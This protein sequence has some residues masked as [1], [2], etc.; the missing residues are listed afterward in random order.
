[1]DPEFADLLPLFVG[2]ARGRVERLSELAARLD[3]DGSAPPEARRE[4]HTL[5]GA[6][7]MLGLAPLAELCHAAEGALKAPK[8]GTG[9]L[10]T[11]VADGLAVMVDAVAQS[12]DPLPDPQLL[13]LLT[14]PDGQAPAVQTPTGAAAGQAASAAPAPSTATMDALADRATRLRILALGAGVFPVRLLEL[15][16]L[17]EAAARGGEPAQAL[18]VLATSLRH[19]GMELEAGQKRLLRLAD[20]HVEKVLTLQVQPLRA[21]FLTV[22]RY[23]REL[24]RSLGREAEIAT[25]GEDTRLDRRILRVIEEAVLHLVR[26][27]IDH[28]IE[29]PDVRQSH[30]KA[31]AGTVRLT[32]SSSGPRV[33]ITIADDGAGVSPAR[34]ARAALE[35]GLIDAS[36]ARGLSFEDAVKLLFSPGFSTRREV[37]EVSGRGIGLDAVA[38]AVSRVGGS[39]RVD[40]QPERGTTIT[41]EVPSALRGEAVLV[42]RVGRLRL[43]APSSMVQRVSRLG[44]A[45]IVQRGGRLLASLGDR[46]VP[47]ISLAEAFGES[48]SEGQLLLEGGAAGQA[49]AITVDAI[50]GEEEVLVRSLARVAQGSSLVEGTALLATGEPVGILSPAALAKHE[51]SRTV[52]VAPLQAASRRLRVLLVDDSLMTREMER[53]LLEDAGFEVMAAGDAAEALAQLAEGSFECVVTDIEMPGM[54]GLELTRRLRTIPHLAQLPVVVVSTRDRPEDRL[55]GLEAGADAYLTKQGL[56]ATELVTVIR[57]LGGR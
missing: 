40:S 29:P 35:A 49:V 22:G 21:F 48:A 37:S 45:E 57:R 11:R 46:L 31:R 4:L 18:A 38:A 44:A 14:T 19:L 28:G 1:M 50:E 41:L 27:A 39:L 15:A 47:F 54:D 10:L 2:E 13:A 12:R 33:S 42:V 56:D 20:S 53:R 9:A 26:N 3:E 43:V 24:A 25:K 17:G 6:A 32:A 23:G 36:A 16:R 30:G 5:K 34:V 8:H 52:S 55:R 51:V 7:R